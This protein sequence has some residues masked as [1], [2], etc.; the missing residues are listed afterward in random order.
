MFTLTKKTDYAIIALAHMA[1]APDGT[2]CTAREV[3][4]RYHLPPALLVNVLKALCHA[5][6]LHSTRGAK[7]GY[8]LHLPPS[9]IT[10]AAIIRSIEGPIRF[11]QCSGDH[12]DG[13]ANCELVNCCPA[14]R[15]VRKVHDQ[16]LEFLNQVTLAQIAFDDEYGE[17]GVALSFEGA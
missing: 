1:N 11:V 5:E 7:G 10:L 2:V 16:M 6:L 15:P 8:S 13:E 17:R 14:T 3:A 12:R 4:E 9:S